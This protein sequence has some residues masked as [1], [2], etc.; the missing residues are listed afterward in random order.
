M[1]AVVLEKRLKPLFILKLISTITFGIFYSSLTL[2]MVHTFNLPATMATSL[3]A[4]FF[5]FHYSSQLIGGKVGD[6]INNYRYLFIIG[7]IFKLLCVL[8]LIYS[9]EHREYMYFGLGCFFVDSIFG[10]TS[11]NMMLTKLFAKSEVK[12]RHD[13][14]VDSNSTE[15]QKAASLEVMKELAPAIIASG[16]HRHA[17]FHNKMIQEIL[18]A[19]TNT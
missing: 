9:I 16:L 10:I 19:N 15:A 2:L 13:Y 11:E 14:F 8:V 7:K 4:L 3:A 1:E 6:Y 17:T 18:I 5:G 12:E